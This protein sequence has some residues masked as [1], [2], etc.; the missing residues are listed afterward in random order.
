MFTDKYIKLRMLFKHE[1]FHLKPTK[2]NI[3]LYMWFFFFFFCTSFSYILLLHFCALYIIVMILLLVWPTFDKIKSLFYKILRHWWRFDMFIAVELKHRHYCKL[4]LTRQPQEF[5]PTRQ[6]LH[7]SSLTQ[8]TDMI[9]IF[10]DSVWFPND[11]LRI[12]LSLILVTNKH[13]QTNGS[14]TRGKRCSDKTTELTTTR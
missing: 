13:P 11:I 12:S 1:F 7:S 6:R 9:N 2:C 3:F 8:H 5:I 4:M 14:E 10:L